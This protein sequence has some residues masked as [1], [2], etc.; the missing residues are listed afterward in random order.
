MTTLKT[1]FLSYLLFTLTIP[2]KATLNPTPI[3]FPN[4]AGSNSNCPSYRYSKC[5]GTTCV[6]CTVNS[7]CD[8]LSGAGNGLCIDASSTVGGVKV[9]QVW[10]NAANRDVCFNMRAWCDDSAS[11]CRQC[12]SDDECTNSGLPLPVRCDTWSFTDNPVCTSCPASGCPAGASCINQKCVACNVHSDCTSSAKPY[13]NVQFQGNT[14]ETCLENLHCG[15]ASASK[16]TSSYVCSKCTSDS[17]CSHILGLNA[18]GSSGCVQCVTNS[19][20]SGPKNL[21]SNNVCVQCIT[22]AD[23][24][25]SGAPICSNNI[26]SPCGGDTDCSGKYGSSLAYCNIGT[27]VQCK[28]SSQCTNPAAPICSNNVCIACSDDP[29]CAAKDSSSPYCSSGKCVQCKISDNCPLPSSAICSASNTC[30]SC[31]GDP[32][33][34]AKYGSS[35]GYCNT[36]TCVQCKDNSHCPTTTAICASNVCSVCTLD[37][38]CSTKYGSGSY[39]Y[40]SGGACVQCKESSHCTTSTAPICSS[41][42]TC[43]ACTSDTVC[44]AKSS[45]SPYCKT[46]G[47][48]VQCKTSNHCTGLSAPI[49]S[50]SGTCSVCT[51]NTDCET[52]Y[53]AGSYSYCNSGTCV[54][55][56]SNAHCP[57]SAPV[58][59]GNTCSPCSGD[60]VCS[61]RFSTTL[62][63][64]TTTGSCA[65]CANNGHCTS[66]SAPICSSSNTCSA[67]ISDTECSGK[68]GSSSYAYC[69]AGSCVQ[70]KTHTHCTNPAAPLCSAS[71]TC[72]ACS[73]DPFCYS[74]YPT[75]L[76]Y[77]SGGACVECTTNTQCLSPAS[78]FCSSGV[79]S[80]CSDSTFCAAKYPGTLT[81]CKS[82]SCV[83]C[84]VD[85]D[86]SG[87]TTPYCNPTTNTCVECTNDSKCTDPILPRCST[88][89]NTCQPCTD[90]SQCSPKFSSQP[91][92]STLI[93]ACVQCV[94]GTDCPLTS[95][96]SASTR[97]C[98]ECTSD[99]HCTNPALPMC[100]A[101]NT[102]Q[103]CT[104]SYFCAMKYSSGT[105]PYCSSTGKCSE[106]TSD[107]HCTNSAKPWCDKDNGVCVE[108]LK[109]SQCA[110]PAK[111]ECSGNTCQSC[112]SFPSV[113][114]QKYPTTLPFCSTGTCVNCLSSTDCTNPKNPICLGNKCVQCLTSNDCTSPSAPY[115]SAGNQC[116]P[117]SNAPTDIC[118]TKFSGLLPL[119]SSSS[120][121]ACVECV[122][123][124]DCSDPNKPNCIDQICQQWFYSPTCPHYDITITQSNSDL[125]IFSMR[126]PSTLASKIDIHSNLKLQLLNIDPSTCTYVLLKLSETA[127]EAAFTCKSSIPATDLEL[128]LPCPS[129]PPYY[130]GDLKVLT[131]IKRIPYTTPEVKE[132]IDTMKDLTSKATT[133]AAASSGSMILLG[134]NPAI[135]WALIGLLQVFFYMIFINVNYPANVQAFFG[136]LTMGSLDF[137]PNPIQWFFPDIENESLDAPARFLE[138]DVD[139]LFLNNAGNEL[140]MW[141]V[142]IVGYIVSKLFLKYTRNMPKLLTTAAGKTVTTLEWSGV[143]RTL[144]TSYTELCLAAFLQIRVLVFDGDLFTVS[145][146]GGIAF[147]I[148]AVA[149]PMI[150]YFLIA[151]FRDSEKY[152]EIKMDT[153]QD[154]YKCEG[155]NKIPL[156]FNV[157]Y[158]LKRLAMVLILIFLH[159]HPYVEIFALIAHYL[160]W[161][162]LISKYL[163]YERGLKN[164]VNIISEALFI[165]IHGLIFFLIRNDH[166]PY[167]T[168]GQQ[169]NIGWGIIAGCLVILG[170]NFILSFIEQ[171]YAL[172]N[173]IKLFIQVIKGKNPAEKKKKRRVRRILGDYYFNPFFERFRTRPD[174]SKKIH[175]ENETQESNMSTREPMNNTTQETLTVESVESAESS[176][177]LSGLS[178]VIAERRH[179]RVGRR[180]NGRFDHMRNRPVGL[181]LF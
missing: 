155:E 129:N 41:S 27:C 26:C 92:C 80:A 3:I 63:H 145:S 68:Y 101:D 113:C 137:I 161:L 163:P 111:A 159:D 34:S 139:G 152:M 19:H 141:F 84:L 158:L 136:L 51:G 168:E 79:C 128:T 160:V 52:K 4:C 181:R 134:A 87:S 39:S 35:L 18:C 81:F 46:G 83:E 53:G 15:S 56:T 9:C 140:L 89:S 118:P 142:V 77:C 133:I 70:C 177:P 10:C 8:H 1:I 154:E 175:P 166:I 109:R 5:S 179:E 31:S 138:N 67:C 64:C 126:F 6:P 176:I 178:G 115:C 74:K 121:G 180:F 132:T 125:N 65:Q 143:L 17:D 43:T 148:F 11:R 135:L 73:G 108:C 97:T 90:S 107:N 72:Q 44:Q 94:T 38:E 86:C 123:D 157:F 50:S 149:F 167:L 164:T 22:S 116:K 28:Y 16:C 162:V 78:P 151:K 12:N 32:S 29:S 103:P 144:I 100:G 150:I 88:T 7:D 40:C 120:N 62:P 173:L 95:I 23:C 60:T 42:F 172:K 24:T 85:N 55:C 57:S 91:V 25:N 174:K 49:C 71:N 2:S 48:C 45:S 153:F 98:V 105:L 117:C 156:N 122:A 165:C 96:C 61:T 171:Y 146:A 66:L 112:S 20:C 110:D 106:C 37:P 47:Q 130:Y 127:Y 30:T 170:M 69:V 124:T 169:L 36:G 14:C 54:Q 114:S 59:S 131:P 76:P 104:S 75:T 102:C 119:C 82:G 21:C 99:N 33:C 93:G 58:C 13:C 147:V